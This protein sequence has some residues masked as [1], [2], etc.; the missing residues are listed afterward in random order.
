MIRQQDTLLERLGYDI[1][2]QNCIYFKD[3]VEE[4]VESMSHYSIEE[5]KSLIQDKKSYIYV[6]SACFYFEVGL[7]NFH[8][9]LDEFHRTRRIPDESVQKSVFG[10]NQNPTLEDT[11]FSVAQFVS[12]NREEEAT[13]SSDKTLTLHLPVYS[14]S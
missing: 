10:D 3:V 8:Q 1:T 13:K 9:S 7:N 2:S 11:I 12:K 4:V 5:V 6:E 14:I